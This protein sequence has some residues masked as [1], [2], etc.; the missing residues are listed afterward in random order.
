MRTVSRKPRARLPGAPWRGLVG[1]LPRGCVSTECRVCVE[2][3]EARQ[4][5]G[6]PAGPL[7]ARVALADGVGPWLLQRSPCGVLEHRPRFRG[8]ETFSVKREEWPPHW[9]VPQSVGRWLLQ[10][11]GKKAKFRV[12][13]TWTPA[14][15]GPFPT[16]LR[17]M[18]TAAFCS[19]DTERVI[20]VGEKHP[21][22]ASHARPNWGPNP[23]LSVSGVSLPPTGPP[24]QGDPRIVTGTATE[25]AH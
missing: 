20:D 9:D 3:R 21:L 13:A 5:V 19:G 16:L 18:F 1:K 25:Q 22:G 11:P 8:Q 10:F 6:A 14:I 4:P 15:Q 24:S 17:G 23:N 2:A 12:S 7:L